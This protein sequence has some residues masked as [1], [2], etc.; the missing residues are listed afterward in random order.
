ML[1][2]GERELAEGQEKLAQAEKEISDGREALDQIGE[3][4]WVVL[5]DKGNA[6]Y[7]YAQGNAD[8]LMSMSTSFS[9]IFLVVGALVI[10]ATITRMV[11]QQRT[12]VGAA[13]ALGLYN[14]EVFAKY[15]FFAAGAGA[16]LAAF[17]TTGAS[18]AAPPSRGSSVKLPDCT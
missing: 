13:K 16:P 11:E 10:Y 8:K 5:N 18:S 14:R 17:Q 15:L 1:T 9:S 12:L 6:G 7:S 4:K 3:C 2:D